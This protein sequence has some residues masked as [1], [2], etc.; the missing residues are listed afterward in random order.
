M[1]GLVRM[2][3]TR[4]SSRPDSEH[5]QA[6][7]R[8]AML[9]LVLAYL[10]IVAGGKPEV[11]NEL[12]LSLSF[13][14]LEYVVSL[15]II[16][17]LL[18]RPG[19][20]LPRRVLGMIADYSLMGVG[21]WLMG[22]LLAPMYVILQW[23]TIGN[24]LR[25]GPRFLYAAISIATG[26]F[27]TVIL[28]TPYWQANPWTAWG[29]LLGLVVVPLYLSSLLRR[30]VKATEAAT[31]ASAAKSR[32]LANMSHELRTPL[33]G[34]VGMAELLVTTPLTA[35]QRDSAQVIQTSARTLQMLVEDILD[36][37]AIEAGKLRRNPADF[38][39]RELVGN[40]NQMLL[41]GARAKGLRFEMRFQQDV[42]DRLHGDSAHLQQILVNLLSNAIK[43]TDSGSVV[44]E[45]SKRGCENDIPTLRFSVRDTGI[46]IAPEALGRIFDAF[47]QA[48]TG[49]G[50]RFGGTG[51]GTTIAKALTEI[52][53]GRIHV[54]STLGS[55]SHFWL[56]V[57]MRPGMPEVATGPGS[58]NV[59]SFSNP[60]VRHRAR[61]RPLRVLV[62]DDQA[63]NLLVLQR[64]LERAGHQ[65]QTVVDGEAVLN[66]LESQRFDVVITDLHMP[67]ISGLEILK[68][69][70]FMQAGLERTPFVVLTADATPE[71]RRECE[72]AGAHA[73]LSKPVVLERLLDT[74]A[75]IAAGAGGPPEPV[76]DSHGDGGEVSRQMLDEL[77]EMGL[78]EQ[79]VQ[80]FLLECAR[81]AR[82]CIVQ[83]QLHGDA[84]QWDAYRDACHALKGAAG[85]MGAV[86]LA[87]GASEAMRLA[88]SA[89][90][91]EWAQ[92]LQQMRQQLEQ[93]I[94]A[95]RR[96]GD[97]PQSDTESDR[98]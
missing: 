52:L 84:G 20:S 8:L 23:V 5:L 41:P 88:N 28:I 62:A 26:T 67:G 45:V 22:D 30:L 51:L 34:I 55:G 70:R 54:E 42:P 87:N 61:V 11:A 53:G 75:E 27:L 33:N 66:A 15:S 18:A 37:S 80:R 57:P 69:A 97:L 59:I 65:P 64:L 21:M 29:L 49:R 35:E 38:N 98:S 71:A 46:G 39:L 48:D 89:L 91:D 73:F 78:G 44:L 90:R 82:K 47:E 10:L 16:G 36:I 92:R 76:V 7:I 81:D 58:D 4:L 68:Q 50:R 25:F 74:L 40:I 13:L 12:R 72:R 2:M 17:W 60:F 3:R 93:S 43:F 63:A 19:I 31:A 86:Q 79:F 85:N 77:R 96:R 1:E 24:G 32:F 6:F 83:L 95:L 9:C 94:T 56:D 14:A